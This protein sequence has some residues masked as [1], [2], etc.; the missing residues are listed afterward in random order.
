MQGRLSLQAV[1]HF[2][3]IAVRV[4]KVDGQELTNSADLLG[5]AAGVVLDRPLGDR[6]HIQKEHMVEILSHGGEIVMHG[7]QV[8]QGYWQRPDAT[9]EVFIEL[10]GKNV[11]AEAD[12]SDG[13][14]DDFATIPGV[15]EATCP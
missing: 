6:A 14:S 7:P 5:G 10:D 9:A 2:D 11:R 4:A 12:F 15:F 3:K 1:T 13:T 8:F